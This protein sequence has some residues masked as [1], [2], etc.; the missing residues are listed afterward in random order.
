MQPLLVEARV[1]EGAVIEPAT[2]QVCT[3]EIGAGEVEVQIDDPAGNPDGTF[4]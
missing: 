1:P 4:G 2:R 3:A